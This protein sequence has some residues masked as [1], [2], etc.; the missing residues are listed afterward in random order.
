MR[1]KIF[2]NIISHIFIFVFTLF[3]AVS[4]LCCKGGHLY[5]VMTPQCQVQTW[6]KAFAVLA[7]LCVIYLMVKRSTY[8][9]FLSE[10]A[11][12]V[13][14][15][16]PDDLSTPDLEERR[17]LKVKIMVDAEDDSKVV[18]WAAKTSD[19]ILPTPQLAYKDTDNVGVAL[20]KDKTATLFLSCP[21]EYMV[22][23]SRMERHVHYR[24]QLGKAGLLGPVMTVP[25][26]CSGTA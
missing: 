23:G 19:N 26:K 18:Y 25:V 1:T 4:L 3:V 9:P 12:P 14:V 15:L 22:R 24:V 16:Q 5:K 6:V 13:S 20:V 10:T 2:A 7:I 11:F 21:G 8:L 17:P